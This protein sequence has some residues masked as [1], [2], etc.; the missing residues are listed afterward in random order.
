MITGIIE[1]FLASC[2]AAHAGGKAVEAYKKRRLSETESELLRFAA[3]HGEFLLMSLNEIPGPWIRVEKVE[4]KDFLDTNDPAYAAKYV[5]AFMSLC[6]R[7]YIRP[8]DGCLFM[9]TG[10][11]FEKARELARKKQR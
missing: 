8:V 6:N 10:S 4:Q 7:V 11:G 3:Q 1:A 5:E 2:Q 9:L